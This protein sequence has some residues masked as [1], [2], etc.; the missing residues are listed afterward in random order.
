MYKPDITHIYIQ[1][2]IYKKCLCTSDLDILF[3]PDEKGT[4]V[5]FDGSDKP[6]LA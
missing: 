4:K 5:M 6:R 3:F 2:C 1:I